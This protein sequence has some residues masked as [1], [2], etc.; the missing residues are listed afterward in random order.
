MRCLITSPTSPRLAT[1]LDFVAQVQRLCPFSDSDVDG[2]PYL[3]LNALVISRPDLRTLRRATR[4]L[5]SAFFKAASALASDVPALIDLG[6]PW[7]AAEVL[8][9]E[10]PRVPIVGRFDFITDQDGRWWVL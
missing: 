8:A 9:A 3:A 1:Y 4:L 6:F 5:S 10:T 7:F 2:E